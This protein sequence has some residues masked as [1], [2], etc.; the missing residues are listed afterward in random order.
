M[1]ETLM[2]PKASPEHTEIWLLPI[3][4]TKTR[5][6]V[7]LLVDLHSNYNNA[8]YGHAPSSPTLALAMVNSPSAQNM[9]GPANQE[10]G[11]AER[12]NGL[13]KPSYGLA[14][15]YT[16]AQARTSPS[17]LASSLA[18][19]KTSFSLYAEG[20]KPGTLTVSVGEADDI[21][22]TVWGNM[23]FGGSYEQ[24]CV[25]RNK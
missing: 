17:A 13:A 15:R 21:G 3:L 19:P 20:G 6:L 4:P 14:N 2:F 16:M 5:Y 9:L 25:T 12:R 23:E 22:H 18:K 8:A 1:K 10:V 11:E 7:I 24:G